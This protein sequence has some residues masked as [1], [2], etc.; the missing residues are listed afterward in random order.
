MCGEIGA[1]TRGALAGAAG[2]VFVKGEGGSGVERDFMPVT[3][4]AG[5]ILRSALLSKRRN[6]WG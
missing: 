6:V 5:L 4:I 2:A 1:S 3:R